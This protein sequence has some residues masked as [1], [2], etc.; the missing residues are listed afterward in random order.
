LSALERCINKT[1]RIRRIK[2]LFKFATKKIRG[3]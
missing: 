3:S 1:I 2:Y